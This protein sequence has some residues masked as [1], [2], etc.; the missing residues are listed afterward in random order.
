[1]NRTAF[2]TLSVARSL[3]ATGINLFENSQLAE[4]ELNLN[5]GYHIDR[6]PV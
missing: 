2:D 6:P 1:M 5:G 4:T 3:E